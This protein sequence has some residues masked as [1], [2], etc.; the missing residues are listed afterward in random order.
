MALALAS[1]N[2]LMR[3]CFHFF[4]ICANTETLNFKNKSGIMQNDSDF[5]SLSAMKSELN[6]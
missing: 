1:L 4:K 2:I 6:Y 5:V 3:F